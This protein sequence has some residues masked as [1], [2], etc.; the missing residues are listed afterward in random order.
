MSN[1][2]VMN[3][4]NA[5]VDRQTIN[6]MIYCDDDLFNSIHTSYANSIRSPVNCESVNN[7][8]GLAGAAEWE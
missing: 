2:S 8:D 4:F 6:A 1:A 7:T 5:R 3:D